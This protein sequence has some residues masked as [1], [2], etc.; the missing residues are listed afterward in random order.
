MS[1]M[2]CPICLEHI[3]IENIEKLKDCSHN[4]CKNCLNILRT[5]Q[6]I[7]DYFENIGIYCPM[8]R[9]LDIFSIEQIENIL[10]ELKN[11]TIITDSEFYA[12]LDTYYEIFLFNNK[13]NNRYKIYDIILLSLTLLYLL[14]QFFVKIQ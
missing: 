10:T 4:F 1:D 14:L 8:C 13:N 3:I 12:T 11:T 7:D 6:I 2:E 5:K 9:K